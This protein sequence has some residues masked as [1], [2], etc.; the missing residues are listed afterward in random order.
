[1]KWHDLLDIPEA[2]NWYLGGQ[3]K[4]A[5]LDDLPDRLYLDSRLDAISGH[6]KLYAWRADIIDLIVLPVGGLAAFA[7]ELGISVALSALIN[8]TVRTATGLSRAA[9]EVPNTAGY[10]PFWWLSWYKC[11]EQGYRYLY[12]DAD[13]TQF[14]SRRELA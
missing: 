6:P 10:N 14:L 13:G 1:M 5:W 4:E 7:K 8:Q 9:D 3:L 2:I 11:Q 12:E